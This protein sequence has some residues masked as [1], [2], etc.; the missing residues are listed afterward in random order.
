MFPWE[1]VGDVW[2]LAPASPI[3]LRLISDRFDLRPGRLED[4]LVES[5]E[6]QF[7]RRRRIYFGGFAYR[8]SE[9]AVNVFRRI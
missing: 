5:R 3:R 8:F 4:R 7:F 2:D 6:Q 9:S 1:W